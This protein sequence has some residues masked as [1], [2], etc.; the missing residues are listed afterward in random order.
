M[1][2]K[3]EKKQ[4]PELE[5]GE[6]KK[7]PIKL[8]IIIVAIVLLLAAVAGAAVY[9]LLLRG[10]NDE[11]KEPDP[12]KKAPAVYA[13]GL[14]EVVSLDSVMDEGAAMLT[15]VE[16]PTKAASEEGID[17]KTYRYKQAE[18][19]AD[20]AASYIE[21]LRG[22]EQGFV[23]VD[24]EN[25]QLAEEPDLETKAGSVILARAAAVEGQKEGEEA[26]DGEDAK[27]FRVIVA[28]SEYALAIQV[29]H[30]PGKILPPPEPEVE[31]EGG[32]PSNVSEQIEFFKSLSPSVLNLPGASMSEYRLYP[33]DGWVQVN[34]F[35]CRQVNV[36]LL[37]MPAGTNTFLGMYFI[38][39]DM[40]QLFT[41]DENGQITNIPLE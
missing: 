32:E 39:D 38:S 34:E 23:P 7:S 13:I 19:P 9:F 11:F 41:M 26:P 14:D 40:K 3:K 20:L 22:E 31:D 27:I 4:K 2:K 1:K 10:G 17:E 37:D 6:K 8:I 18:D 30:Q 16:A 12:V 5:Q 28:W 25:R 29:S 33:M 36:Y 24:A 15:T 35:P 21:V